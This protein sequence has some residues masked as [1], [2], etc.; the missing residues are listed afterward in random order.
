MVYFAWFTFHISEIR[1]LIVAIS[2]VVVMTFSQH[3]HVRLRGWVGEAFECLEDNKG[4]LL[5][6]GS[7]ILYYMSTSTLKMASTI[8]GM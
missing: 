7:I 8:L 5:G 1:M 3:M 6:N 2:E 4:A